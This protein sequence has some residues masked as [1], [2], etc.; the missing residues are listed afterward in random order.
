MA[1]IVTFRKRK[2]GQ[3]GTT[4]A[5][6]YAHWSKSHFYTNDF[7]SGTELLYKD[8]FPAGHFH[9]MPF[10]TTEIDLVGENMV[11][12]FGGFPDPRIPD[13][14]KGSDLVVVPYMFQSSADTTAF[15]ETI[16]DIEK[17]SSDILIAIN[18]TAPKNTKEAIAD[19]QEIYDDKYPV[20]VI[21]PSEFMK[22]FMVEGKTPF[23]MKGEGVTKKHL[24]TL[25]G[26]LFDLFT[27]IKG[28]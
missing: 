9:T 18:N 4:L 15:M 21:K 14:V 3:G 7:D 24:K 25:Q 17:D 26:Q 13:V 10:G 22:Y 1:K 23:D 28:Y 11:F 20:K 8:K 12:D 27:F 16:A 19:I 5:T 6:L 2:G